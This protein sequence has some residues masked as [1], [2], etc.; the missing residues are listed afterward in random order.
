ME[1]QQILEILAKMNGKM[2]ANQA[3]GAKA[4]DNQEDLL[5]RMEARIKTNRQKDREDLKGMMEEA[6]AGG[7]QEEMLARMREDIKSGQAEVRSTVCAFQSDLEETIQQ[8]MKNF[9]SYVDQK[10]QNL[11]KYYPWEAM[12]Q[13]QRLVHPSKQFCNWFCGMAFRAENHSFLHC[14][15]TALRVCD[16]TAE[17]AEIT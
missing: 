11:P 2:D 8:K 5:A 14:C 16:V 15:V 13:C 6:K 10:T 17:P 12:H 9:L 3:D 7:K 1:T 4:N